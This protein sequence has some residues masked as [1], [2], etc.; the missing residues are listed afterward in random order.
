[1]R[2]P[3]S[4]IASGSSKGA[5]GSKCQGCDR[6]VPHQMYPLPPEGISSFNLWPWDEGAGKQ[7]A[8]LD[9][10]SMPRTSGKTLI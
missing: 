8:N 1:M 3:A 4:R 6:S 7:N 2:L 9:A 10:G 5:P